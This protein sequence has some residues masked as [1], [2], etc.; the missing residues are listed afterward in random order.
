VPDV[1]QYLPNFGQA[2]SISFEIP[3]SANVSDYNKEQ[4]LTNSNRETV[5]YGIGNSQTF[6]RYEATRIYKATYS[7]MGSSGD[8]QIFNRLR[9][10]R[11]AEVW[12][13]FFLE[14][15]AATADLG[16]QTTANLNTALEMSAAHLKF[17]SPKVVRLSFKDKKFFEVRDLSNTY[18]DVINNERIVVTSPWSSSIAPGACRLYF[19]DTVYTEQNVPVLSETDKIHDVSVT[20]QNL[21]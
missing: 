8:F 13:P 2:S 1:F 18:Q 10:L 15:L 16:G 17:M 14:P 12:L 19:A 7:E 21:G 4:R 3:L 11:G 9:A 20:W 6:Y 5:L